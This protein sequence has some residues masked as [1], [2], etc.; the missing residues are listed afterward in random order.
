MIIN[1][2]IGVESSLSFSQDV[3]LRYI[4]YF[5]SSSFFA[6]MDSEMD[7]KAC[8]SLGK[9]PNDDSSSSS[10]K[11][12]DVRPHL[13][14]TGYSNR[15]PS[16]SEFIF[17]KVDSSGDL[18]QLNNVDSEDVSYS[19]LGSSSSTKT[20]E[21]AASDFEPTTLLD[22][23]GSDDDPLKI[24]SVDEDEGAASQTQPSSSKPKTGSKGKTPIKKNYACDYPGCNASFSRPWK[25]SA[26]HCR[27]T[28]ERPFMCS[29]VGCTKSYTNPTHLR[30]HDLKV[31][32]AKDDK[33]ETR[34]YKC[35]H[36]NC[37]LVD[38]PG[39]I[40]VP[41]LRKHEQRHEVL[42]KNGL[43][44]ADCKM[45]FPRLND[46]KTHRFIHDNVLP[47]KCDN[48]GN[49]YLYNLEYR[50]HLRSH[51]RYKCQVAG[52]ES[53]EFDSY[54]ELQK[55]KVTHNK[56]IVCEFCGK[57]FAMQCRLR[58]HLEETHS[59]EPG[60]TQ[61]PCSVQ[62]CPR[63]FT[64]RR[65]MQQHVRKKHQ[66][67]GHVCPFQGCHLRFVWKQSLTKH[68]QL[69]LMKPET[70]PIEPEEKQ[71]RPRARRKD[72][73][74]PKSTT[75]EILSNVIVDKQT[76]D[77]LLNK[78]EFDT[79]EEIIYQLTESPPLSCSSNAELDVS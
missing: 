52:C 71:K 24:D 37:W 59:C 21:S 61:W 53:L 7:R 31:H 33:S 23:A 75:A 38:H 34:R 65:N 66:G 40:T 63:V 35:T 15:L 8:S 39:F 72:A 55:H 46:L 28:G 5:G 44:C 47:F 20:D 50:K 22:E 17:L 58:V 67:P 78:E 25:L 62:G 42:D 51:K 43:V 41:G 70:P 9:F 3:S 19:N 14:S 27:H 73:D 54:R 49:A 64:R 18:D 32:G 12:S 2:L 68:M 76:K 48:C 26:H 1:F 36:P 29:R 79:D 11:A 13:D 69:H 57:E 45:T 30:R 77:Q 16:E 10:R 60:A 6:S 56:Q 74:K 4:K